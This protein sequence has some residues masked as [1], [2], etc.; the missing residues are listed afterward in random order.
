MAP[1]P[2]RFPMAVS[3]ELPVIYTKTLPYVHTESVWVLNLLSEPNSTMHSSWSHAVSTPTRRVPCVSVCV[4]P[5]AHS[6][7]YR[8]HV[9]A[10]MFTLIART[11]R[12]AATLA[13]T[14]C[15]SDGIPHYL[16]RSSAHWV[17]HTSERNKFINHPQ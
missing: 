9:R 10:S 15:A 17:V 13:K 8:Q 14:A 6:R 11:R 4:C 12:H 7:A 1:P 5:G 2:E 16:M 3:T